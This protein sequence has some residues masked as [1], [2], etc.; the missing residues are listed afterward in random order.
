M[1]NNYSNTTNDLSIDNHT[2]DEH[3]YNSRRSASSNAQ[4]STV[5]GPS[6]G[7]TIH[8]AEGEVLTSCSY[9]NENSRFVR[10]HTRTTSVE[11]AYFRNDLPV[12]DMACYANT[13]PPLEKVGKFVK[14]PEFHS[15]N[16]RRESYLRFRWPL[17]KPTAYTLANADMF[18]LGSFK[19][20]GDMITD[21][22]TCYKC[23]QVFRHW[24]REDDPLE[25]H[26]KIYPQCFKEQWIIKMCE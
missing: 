16:G 9:G 12:P 17:E 21:Q 15:L 23:G 13:P 14:H 7:R 2:F 6:L 1:D 22:V 20:D 8:T 4:S 25:E 3:I 24:E 19:E 5:A 26:K 10:S 18:F 11:G